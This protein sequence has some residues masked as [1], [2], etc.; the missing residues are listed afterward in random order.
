VMASACI[1]PD[2]DIVVIVDN[3]GEEWLASTPNAS[4]YNGLDEEKDIQTVDEHWVATTYCL[5][6]AQGDQLE[7]WDSILYAETLNDI[8]LKCK[9]RAYDMGLGND[10]CYDVATI[11]Y[12]GTCTNSGGCNDEGAGEETAATETGEHP[13]FGDLDLTE[14]VTLVRGQ[15]VISQWLIDTALAD[16]VG[17]G[18]DG[19][20]VTQ[21]R[22]M[23]GNP[24]GFKIYGVTSTNLGGVLGLQNGDIITEVS[25]QPTA[26]YDDLLDVAAIVL[27]ASTATVEL[28]R[29]TVSVTLTYRRGT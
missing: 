17:V 8:I 25:N 1:I 7:D 14:E 2:K 26:T 24:Y 11:V 9:A 23:T 18:N 20:T 4:G 13:N 28:T 15:Y 16:P 22:D 27:S 12:V 21:V 3:C 5:T 10:N 29:G 6:P 19:T